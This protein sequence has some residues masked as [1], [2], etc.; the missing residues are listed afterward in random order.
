[1]DSLVR[2]RRPFLHW[3]Y[4]DHLRRRSGFVQHG[5]R[6]VVFCAF[7]RHASGQSIDPEDTFEDDLS[8]MA[9]L[10][11]V[12]ARFKPSPTRAQRKFL[13]MGYK[14]RS[15]VSRMQ[16]HEAFCLHKK[17]SV[18]FCATAGSANASCPN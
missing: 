5:Q 10:A 4:M 7:S 8:L 15:K 18:L 9:E 17:Y 11:T 16:R 3:R 2:V 6:C 1:M 12:T 14:I 13:E